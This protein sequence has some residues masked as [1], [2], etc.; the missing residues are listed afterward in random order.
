MGTDSNRENG[1]EREREQKKK[2]PT[3]MHRI[4]NKSESEQKEAQNRRE[5]RP[6]FP[7]KKQNENGL[8]HAGTDKTRIQAPDTGGACKPD[9]LEGVGG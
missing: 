3:H 4:K 1:R 8:R 9:S 6:N 5:E 2:K 7:F